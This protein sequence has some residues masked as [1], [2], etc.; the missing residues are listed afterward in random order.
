M[1]H[2]ELNRGLVLLG[3]DRVVDRHAGKIHPFVRRDDSGREDGGLHPGGTGRRNCQPDGAVGDEDV[4]PGR[5]V[6]KRPRLGKRQCTGFLGFGLRNQVHIVAGVQQ[7]RF[8]QVPQAQL[9]APQVLEDSHRTP[10][11]L[12]KPPDVGNHLG[13]FVQGAV[14][15][16]Q[17][18]AVDAL[19][20]EPV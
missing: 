13:V 7:D 17:T 18:G 15:E 16:I 19:A 8:F 6:P 11:F 20:D 2:A 3:Q 12:G 9:D 10:V 4:V 14:G 5:N 1:L